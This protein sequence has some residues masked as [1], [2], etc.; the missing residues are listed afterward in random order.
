MGLPDAL[1][2][3]G[4]RRTLAVWNQAVAAGTYEAEYRMRRHDPVYRT[5]LRQGVPV[6]G[7]V[8]LD[9]RGAIWLSAWV[10]AVFRPCS[11]QQKE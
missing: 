5:L 11:K 6:L 1:H 9:W 10:F 3:D 7:R 8:I 4:L 2:S